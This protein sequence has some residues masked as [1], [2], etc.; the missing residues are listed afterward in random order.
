MAKG[1]RENICAEEIIKIIGDLVSIPSHPGVHEQETQAARYIHQFFKEK[2]IESDLSHVIDG[3]HNVIA[4]IPGKGQGYSLLLTGHLD[5]VPP[6]DMP[7]PFELKRENGKVVGRG[8]VDMKGP[9]A[10]MIYAMALIKECSLALSGD[11]IFAGVVGEET[12]C[13]GTM[14]LLYNG[15]SPDGAV[16]GE[17]T[18]LHIGVGHRGLEWLEFYFPGKA[19]HGG[20]QEKGI[21]AISHAVTFINRLNRDLIP[22]IEKRTHPVI[23]CS[24]MNLGVIKGGTQPST[25]AHECFLQIDRRWVPGEKYPDVVNEYQRILTCLHQ[26]DENFTGYLRSMSALP[27]LKYPFVCEPLEIDPHHPLV[28]IAQQA[29]R[30]ATGKKS[31]LVP[32]PAW[33][34]GGLL[35]TYGQIPTI[36]LGPGDFTS[37]H[38]AKEYLEVAQVVPG[39]LAYSLLAASFCSR[40]KL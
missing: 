32:F 4:R 8:V 40:K 9:L 39:A 3:R 17:P 34:D 35:S 11:L 27:G 16:V 30:S 10:C 12:D 2:G 28:H 37:A 14:D 23:G 21:N 29:L 13:Q 24:S 25:V 22:Q 19:V 1:F 33:T 7:D 31:E 6:Y 15:L 20:A 18:N 36:I 38:T 5:T 26:E